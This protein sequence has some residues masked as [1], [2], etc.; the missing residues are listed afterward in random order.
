MRTD[1]ELMLSYARG[2]TA[3]FR[4]IFQRYAAMLVRLLTRYVGRV[5]DAQDIAQQTFLQLHRARLD[6][7]ADMRLRPWV[8]TIALNLARDHLRRRG[9]RTETPID[10]EA[11]VAP[12]VA[13]PS[14]TEDVRRRVRLAV[15][16][17]PREQRE[18]IEL[19]WFEELPFHEIASVLG[20]SA[21]AARVRAHRGYVSLRE[22]LGDDAPTG[23]RVAETE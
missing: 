16:K 22:E 19:H 6:F 17:L 13:F 4:E 8:I 12:E 9:R 11:L 1:E 2:D 18:V 14:D 5:A 21:G 15:E 20:I 23:A 7:R 3:S 10:A